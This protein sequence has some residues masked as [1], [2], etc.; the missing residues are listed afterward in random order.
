MVLLCDRGQNIWHVTLSSVNPEGSEQMKP[1]AVFG[2]LN[3]RLMK[4]NGYRGYLEP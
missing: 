2:K 1:T 4:S 3:L